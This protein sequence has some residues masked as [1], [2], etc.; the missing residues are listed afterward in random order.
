MAAAPHHMN[1]EKTM[2]SPFS[3]NEKRTDKEVSKAEQ[4]LYETLGWSRLLEFHKQENSYLKTRLSLV[5]DHHAG[6][7][8]FLTRAEQYQN[9]FLQKDDFIEELLKDVH[10]QEIH[11]TEPALNKK[12]LED[13]LV[14]KQQKLR[15]EVESLERQF[16]DLKNGFHKYLAD[17]L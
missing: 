13:K 17:I 9:L 11:L 15:N 5:V 14:R 12:P 8:D 10:N 1:N 2:I 3:K 6:A 16:A 4:F 7:S